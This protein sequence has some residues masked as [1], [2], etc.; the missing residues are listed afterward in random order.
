MWNPGAESL[1]R[2]ET[3]C[4]GW[5]TGMTW[6]GDGEEIEAGFKIS[7]RGK[8]MSMYGPQSH[9][10]GSKVISLK[11]NKFLKENLTTWFKNTESDIFSKV[12]I[13][14]QQAHEKIQSLSSREC[15]SRP[16]RYHRICQEVVI[17]KRPEINVGWIWKGTLIWRYECAPTAISQKTKIKLPKQFPI[18]VYIEKPKHEM[19]HEPQY[20]R[21]HH[22]NCQMSVSIKT[23][24]DKVYTHT[25]ARAF[26]RPSHTR[27]LLSHK[28]EGILLYATTWVYLNEISDRERQ[29]LKY[30]TY[31]WN[32]KIYKTN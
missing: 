27:L 16:Q 11:L 24:I 28:N 25:H 29:I 3:R 2:H 13:G 31:M 14:G 17:I 19:I 7:S 15:K 6:N 12:Y 20:S 4:S 8:F 18:L 23:R 10:N 21:R 30:I 26:C 5:C 32:L 22:L 9:Y 1:V